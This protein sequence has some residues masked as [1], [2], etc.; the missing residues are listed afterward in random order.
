MSDTTSVNPSRPRISF[1]FYQGIGVLMFAVGLSLL[2]ARCGGGGSIT[3]PPTVAVIT[4]IS[5]IYGVPGQPFS[6]QLT[7]TGGKRPYRWTALSQLPAGWHLST[8]G[9]IT[10]PGLLS[11][12]EAF[13]VTVH[14]ESAP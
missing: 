9:M 14:V 3:P 4:T 8:D 5:P 2:T 10:G 13:Q 6:Y 1:R 12:K 11:E 7:A